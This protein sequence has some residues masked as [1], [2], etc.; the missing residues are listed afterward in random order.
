MGV[1]EVKHHEPRRSGHGRQTA[2]RVCPVAPAHTV[3]LVDGTTSTS[4]GSLTLRP[5][6]PFKVHRYQRQHGGSAKQL[7]Q[8]IVL[9]DAGQM[10]GSPSRCSVHYREMHLQG[11]RGSGA[12]VGQGRRFDGADAVD[13]EKRGGLD[14]P[15]SRPPR[16]SSAQRRGGSRRERAAPS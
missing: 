14:G 10:G 11:Q 7:E 2:R 15:C 8:Q 12:C 5:V 6:E 4:W 9:R 13:G 1:P 3:M 16:G